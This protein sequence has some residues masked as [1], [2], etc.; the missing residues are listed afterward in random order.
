ML[1]TFGCGTF[2][3][4]ADDDELPCQTTTTRKSKARKDNPFATRGLD[5][6]SALLADLDEKRQ[7]IYSQMNPHDIS[8]VRFVYSSTNDFVPIVV[9]VNNNNKSQELRVVK[10]R[11]L[12]HHH[13]HH[14]SDKPAVESSAIIEDESKQPKLG[15]GEKKVKKKRLNWNLKSFDVWNPCFYVPMVM[16]LILVFLTI[17]GRTVSA[18]CTCILWYVIPAS[19]GSDRSS[20]SS[21][22]RK[23]SKKKDYAR[24]V[25]EIKKI[26]INEGLVNSEKKMVVNEEKVK[27]KKE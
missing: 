22:S 4:E 8:F 23:P 3:H 24:G 27:I 20:S 26:A 12:D 10:P 15:N 18:L 14:Q 16:I 13:H 19:K 9:K 1:K 17:F 6:F 21:N 5:K 25:S 2:H 7:R 11:K